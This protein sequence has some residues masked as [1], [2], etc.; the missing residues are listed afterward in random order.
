MRPQALDVLPRADQEQRVPDQQWL[1]EH[2]TLERLLTAT[3]P[4][5]PEPIAIAER[6][7]DHSLA[8]Q[9]GV[10]R[11]HDLDHADLLRPV[12]EVRPGERQHLE[13]EALPERRGVGVP[14]EHVDQHDVVGLQRG[15]LRGADHV[16]REAT[17]ALD[18]DQ[19]RADRVQIELRQ[20]LPHER[21]PVRHAHAMLAAGEAVPL[22]PVAQRDALRAP[23]LVLV[24]GEPAAGEEHVGDPEDQDRHAERGEAEELEPGRLVRYRGSHVHQKARRRRRQRS[25]PRTG[26]G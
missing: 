17:R 21:R 9:R 5:H 11:H 12:A 24:G 7:F 14:R 15:L 23:A 10:G 6:G 8:R 22:D 2:A 1:V 13:V 25:L 20:G 18:R 26:C 16:S 4:D 3:E 19:V